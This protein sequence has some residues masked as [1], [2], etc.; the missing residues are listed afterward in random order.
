MQRISADVD[1]LLSHKETIRHEA[2]KVV[3]QF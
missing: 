2:E 3:E 1:Y